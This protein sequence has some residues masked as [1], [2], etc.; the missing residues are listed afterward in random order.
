MENVAAFIDRDGTINE[1][2]GY[3]YRI[4]DWKWIA[5]SIKA[6]KSLNNA[7]ILV[8][9]ISNQA[10]V[11][12]G[13]Y[14]EYKIEKLHAYVD[15]ELSRAGAKIDA[16][17]Y[18]PHH[19]EFGVIRQCNCRKPLPGM[20]LRAKKD[21]D[22]DLGRSYMI[23]DKM[24]D[25]EA[26]K[27]AGVKPIMVLTGY[28]TQHYRQCGEEV[29]CAENLLAASK[30]ILRLHKTATDGKICVHT[31]GLDNYLAIPKK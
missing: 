7:G 13:K 19:P 15:S 14:T 16:Y 21:F 10:G 18:C 4:E 28:G 8:I 17:Y 23:G 6:I 30:Y 12:R 22:I 9:V 31:I 1:E 3:L 24:G 27:A 26:G 11:A 25:V 2:K 29:P 5:G 20:I